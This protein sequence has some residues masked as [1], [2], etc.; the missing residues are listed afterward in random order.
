MV[1]VPRKDGLEIRAKQRLVMREGF[2]AAAVYHRGHEAR[3]S[4]AEAQP[5]IDE[6]MS[7]SVAAARAAVAALLAA[8]D[9]ALELAAILAGS[10]RPLPGLEAILRSHPLV[11]TAE[12]EMYRS[13]L[14]RACEALG[15][16]VVRVPAKGLQERAAAALGL[17]KAELSDRLES[18]GKASGKPWTAELRECAL[19]GWMALTG[20]PDR[21]SRAAR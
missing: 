16:R 2:H 13:A 11:H 9:C 4:A 20:Q 14:S 1:I 18:A 8:D 12:G 21:P 19:A 5:I 3:L 7:A 6:A 15:L 17:S 10:S